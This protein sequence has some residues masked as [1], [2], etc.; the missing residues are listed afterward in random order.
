MTKSK[1]NAQ[2]TTTPINPRVLMFG[3][4]ALALRM[5]QQPSI[6]H[7]RTPNE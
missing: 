4:R 3:H 5:T 6:V 7:I 1:K 2:T